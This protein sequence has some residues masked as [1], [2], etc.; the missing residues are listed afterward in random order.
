MVKKAPAPEPSD[1]KTAA[2]SIRLTEDSKDRLVASKAE[3][4]SLNDEIATRLD[5]SLMFDE[6]GGNAGELLTA[7]AKIGRHLKTASGGQDWSQSPWVAREFAAGVAQI[8]HELGA[9]G[10]VKAPKLQKLPAGVTADNYG[11]TMA[12]YLVVFGDLK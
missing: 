10:D 11:R 2:L 3:S 1:R 4:R 6:L 9:K 8:V 7:I 12:E 5:V